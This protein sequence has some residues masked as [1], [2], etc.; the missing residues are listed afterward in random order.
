MLVVGAGDE[1]EAKIIKRGSRLRRRE[2]APAA[3]LGGA[4]GKAVPIRPCRIE[5]SHFDMDGIGVSCLGRNFAFADYLP[6]ARILCN[7]ISHRNI[8]TGHS[9]RRLAI[10]R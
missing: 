1:T 3:A 4:T 5:A 10:R 2:R 9:A 8:R 6:E 7:F